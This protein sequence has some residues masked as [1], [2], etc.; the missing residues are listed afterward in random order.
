MMAKARRGVKYRVGFLFQ[1]RPVMMDRR[2]IHMHYH[3]LNVREIAHA[4][5]EALSPIARKLE[6]ISAEVQAVL[7]KAAEN[8]TLVG[9]VAEG[10]N[11]LKIQVGDLQKQIDDLKANQ[12]LSDEDKAAL[13]TAAGDLGDAINILRQNIPANTPQEG[14]APVT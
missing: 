2:E 8:E 10:M 11:A 14:E 1:E 4:L 12:T 6:M 7:D 3:G 13:A 9:S 5:R